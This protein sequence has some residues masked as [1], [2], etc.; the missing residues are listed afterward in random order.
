MM[1]WEALGSS[2]TAR[3]VAHG[4]GTGERRE[5]REEK[6]EEKKIVKDGTR[7]RARRAYSMSCYT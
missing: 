4:V 6:R 1:S 7:T 5:R 2:M 3:S